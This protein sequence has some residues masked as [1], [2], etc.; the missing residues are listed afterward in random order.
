MNA[1]MIIT[2]E[3]ENIEQGDRAAEGF[4]KLMENVFARC[5]PKKHNPR[6]NTK[7]EW[8]GA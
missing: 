3:L 4:T 7:I 8:S 2:V 6:V 5:I 1:K